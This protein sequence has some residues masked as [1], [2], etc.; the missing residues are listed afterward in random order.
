M[1]SKGKGKHSAPQKAATRAKQRS[2]K[3]NLPY[4]SIGERQNVLTLRGLGK[5][6]KEIEEA[7]G[8]SK[9]TIC[10]ILDQWKK[11]KKLPPKAKTGRPSQITSTIEDE[12]VAMSEADRLLTS[13]HIN[14]LLRERYPEI[15]VSDSKIRRVLVKN[16]LFGRV[17]SRKTLLRAANKAEKA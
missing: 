8:I 5:T 4:T 12:I 11:T 1:K 14:A 9:A 16:G 15:N 13:T 10:R 17:C 6:L 7:M 2:V 3:Y